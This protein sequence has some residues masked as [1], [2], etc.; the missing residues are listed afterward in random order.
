MKRLKQDYPSKD[1]CFVLGADLI[2]SLKAWQIATLTLTLTLTLTAAPYRRS[3]PRAAGRPPRPR[4]DH[5]AASHRL[6]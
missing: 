3:R 5:A 1:F 2:D 6:R 4:A